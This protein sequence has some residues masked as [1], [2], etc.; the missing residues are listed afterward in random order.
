VIVDGHLDVAWNALYSGRD[1]TLPL[2]AL[3]ASRPDAAGAMTSLPAFGDAGVGLVFA[4]LFTEP[5]ESWLKGVFDEPELARPPRRYS[6]PEEAEEHALEMLDVY[7]GW[8]DRGLVRI[9]TGRAT[10]AEHV[11]R[12][13]GD[14]VPGLVILMEG[15]DPIVDVAD[16]PA[17]WDRGVRMIGLAWGSTRYAG[18]TGA[19]TG[20]TPAGAELLGAMAELGVIHDASHL[21]EESFW[22]AVGLPHHALCATHVAS[23]PLMDRAGAAAKVPL[24]RFLTDDQVA[25]VS[26][27]GGVIGLALLNDF[28][29]P[30]W[31]PGNGTVLVRDQVAA[32]LARI[33]SVAGW[34]HVGIGSDI[35]AGHGRDETPAEL[36]SVADWTRIADA[37]PAGAREGVLGGNW[38]RFLRG[39][40]PDE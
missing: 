16:L 22:D 21:S 26:A 13:A 14:R 40:L 15:A 11:E 7:R 10:L 4:T 5:A 30:G 29:E 3:R 20:L 38:L 18:G 6:T 28:L 35:D 23:R 39:A 37:V 25:A 36:D 31:E 24:N 9:I 2:A 27:R 12:F 17:W 1:L 33:A 32:H 8:A 34:E 19:S